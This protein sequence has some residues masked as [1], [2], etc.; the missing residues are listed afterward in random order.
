MGYASKIT[1]GVD[2]SHYQAPSGV[3]AHVKQLGQKI[4]FSW[5][6]PRH[7]K[8]RLLA[9]GL[10]G[11]GRLFI[12]QSCAGQCPIKVNVP[13]FKAKFLH[14]YHSRYLRPLKDYAVA[15]LE[16]ALPYAAKPL[17]YTTG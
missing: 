11:L 8:Q 12:L 9:S 2:L 1:K 16:Y 5:N 10:R 15:S 17:L 14:L 3:L 13:D 7:K 4:R 6:S